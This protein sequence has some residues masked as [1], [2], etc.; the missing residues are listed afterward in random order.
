MAII[1]TFF[2]HEKEQY[3]GILESGIG[4]GML[5]G[6]LLGAFLNQIGGYAMPF[7]TVGGVCIALY[8]LLLYTV[9]FIQAKEDAF[10][11]EHLELQANEFRMPINDANAIREVDEKYE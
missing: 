9:K 2:P 8:P 11:K 4:V 1:T 6:P 7:W 3:I 5:V 10:N